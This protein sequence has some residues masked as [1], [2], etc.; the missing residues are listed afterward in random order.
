MMNM[1]P[2]QP[3]IKAVLI[4]MFALMLEERGLLSY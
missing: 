1:K 3:T 4:A 2:K